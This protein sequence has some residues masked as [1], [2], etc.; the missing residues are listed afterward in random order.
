M[1]LRGRLYYGPSSPPLGEGAFLPHLFF[2][3]HSYRGADQTDSFP[4][5]SETYVVPHPSP[6]CNFA[7]STHRP[8]IALPS[9]HEDGEP[10]TRMEW[11]D[12]AALV[13]STPG[14]IIRFD[15]EGTSAGVFVWMHPGNKNTRPELMP[16]KAA[17]WID[18]DVEKGASFPFPPFTFSLLTTFLHPNSCHYQRLLNLHQRSAGLRQAFRGT[19][20]GQAVRRLVLL[21]LLS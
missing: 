9:T 16:G 4:Q 19:R 7:S 21:S 2:F 8:L 18:G 10:W 14:E 3:L 12:K 5:F 15:V 1:A 13:S 20:A 17:C 6:V 11:N